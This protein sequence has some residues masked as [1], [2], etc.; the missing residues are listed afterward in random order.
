MVD[1][2]DN[3]VLEIDS[4]GK[5]IKT[6]QPCYHFWKQEKRCANC[7]SMRCLAFRKGFSKIVLLDGEVFHVLS[8]YVKIDDKPLVLETLVRI[9]GDELLDGNGEILPVGSLFD[10]HSQLYLDPVTRV[11]NRRYYDTETRNGE[12]ICALAVLNVDQFQD[13]ADTYG[14]EA[15]DNLLARVA[16]SIHSGLREP[17]TLIRYCGAEFVMLF[18]SIHPDA[19]EA[20]LNKICGDISALSVDGTENGPYITASIGGAMGPDGPDALLKK[21]DEMLLKAKLN[22]G[23]VELWRQDSES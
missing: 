8:R 16:Q 18:A 5:L 17:D 1:P 6:G 21:A 10:M 15:G 12:K 23:R 11:Y 9:T 19:L 3:S 22:R 2:T 4:S 13:I 7:T 20:R 14:R